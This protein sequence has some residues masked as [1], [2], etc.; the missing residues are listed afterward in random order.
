MWHAK[1]YRQLALD[2]FRVLSA[3]DLD[4]SLVDENYLEDEDKGRF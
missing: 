4:D 2:K 3:N 1:C